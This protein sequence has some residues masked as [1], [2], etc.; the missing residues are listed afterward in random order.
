M[1]PFPGGLLHWK[2]V[3]GFLLNLKGSKLSNYIP[4]QL[5]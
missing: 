2:T 5:P 1:G 3:R 4:R